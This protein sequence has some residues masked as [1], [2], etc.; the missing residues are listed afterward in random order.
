M[1]RGVGLGR[2]AVVD[3]GES[4]RRV[5][6]AVRE[7]ARAGRAGLVVAVHDPRDRPGRFA[8]E[9][10]ASV[11]ASGSPLEV[12]RAARAESAWL[13][14]ATLVERAAFAEACGELGVRHLGPPAEALRRLAAPGGLAGLA[15]QLGIA[16]GRVEGADPQH[17]LVE[18][19][20]ARDERGQLRI[21]GVGDASLRHGG[22]A[23]L[24]ESPSPALTAAGD[25]VARDLAARAVTAAGWVGVAAVQ[26]LVD[27]HTRGWS[28]VGVDAFAQSGP[29]VEALAGLDVIAL[30]LRLAAGDALEGEA[31]P[32]HGHAFA[33][34]IT[35]RAPGEDPARPAGRVMLLRLPSRLG[36]RADAAVDEGERAPAGDAVLAT[37]VARGEARA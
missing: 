13:G 26:L 34:R 5:L 17:H 3:G 22:V 19:L 37:V 4:A 12:L 28:L 6:R 7:L 36:V 1:D 25:S 24:A 9:A 10:D 18:V 33:A 2:V 11:D 27:P 23:V 20:V 8:R 31:V 29:A 35:V 15:E 21:L 32:L 16:L 30:A 14:P